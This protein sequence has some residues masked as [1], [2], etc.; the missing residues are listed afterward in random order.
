LPVTKNTLTL[1]EIIVLIFSILRQSSNYYPKGGKM[2]LNKKGFTLV[3]LM[4]VV[5]II[6]ILAAVAVPKFADLINKSK[7][8]ATKGGLSAVRG[9]LHVYYGNNEGVFPTDTSALV[10]QYINEIPTAKLPGTGHSDSAS[11]TPLPTPSNTPEGSSGGGWA[12]Y[13]HT[14]STSATYGWFGVNCTH[15]D[16]KGTV[17]STY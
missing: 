4:I 9:A 16:L 8:G 14:V 12:Y 2:K 6:G 13:T 15:T 5:A 1:K 10:P 3:E 11:V 17:W 7:E